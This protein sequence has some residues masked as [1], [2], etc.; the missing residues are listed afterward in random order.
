MSKSVTD[1]RGRE[2]E[3]PDR[4]VMGKTTTSKVYHTRKCRY[5]QT[6]AD[7]GITARRASDRLIEHKE[8]DKCPECQKIEIDGMNVTEVC[9]HARTNISGYDSIADY[10]SE[11]NIPRSK[12]TILRHVTDQCNCEH[13][14]DPVEYD[15][16]FEVWGGPRH[17][18]TEQTDIEQPYDRFFVGSTTRAHAYHTS[19]CNHVKTVLS[20]YPEI[21][22]KKASKS[23]IS[24]HDID[25]CK[26]CRGVCDSVPSQVN[27][28]Y[29]RRNIVGYTDSQQFIDE[30]NISYSGQTVTRHARGDCNCDCDSRPAKW[31]AKRGWVRHE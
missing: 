9:K 8:M 31:D 10:K 22:L 26:V 14:V 12:S 15:H 4:Y 1:G 6:S 21:T 11:Y 2:I 23:A 25:E 3:L 29:I 30:H 18:N 7:G 17:R 24:F 20:T 16:T 28:G 5:Y 27:C 19:V 13:S